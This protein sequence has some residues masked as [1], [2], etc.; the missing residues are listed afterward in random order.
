MKIPILKML[1][2]ASIFI[3][4][5]LIPIWNCKTPMPELSSE[6]KISKKFPISIR[7]TTQ[8]PILAKVLTEVFP[9]PAALPVEPGSPVSDLTQLE[10]PD[11]DPKLAPKPKPVKELK[12]NEL[13]RWERSFELS[14]INNLTVIIRNETQRPVYS[15]G[16]SLLALT[17][18]Y[19]AT[20]ETEAELV[21]VSNQDSLHRVSF[22]STQ[23]SIWAPMPFYIG[24]G[25]SLVSPLLRSNQYP[26]QLQRYCIFETPSKLRQSIEQPLDET[27]KDYEN[28]LR[29][30]LIQNYDNIHSQLKEWETRNQDWFQP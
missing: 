23:E 12:P 3:F 5:S 2:S 13:P 24:T 11:P 30:L 21:W 7:W 9:V 27:C 8:D 26:S 22:L 16:L 18:L 14:K 20:M 1:A 10:L 19:Y 4:T 25:S 29:R 17:M 28:F 15:V 6:A